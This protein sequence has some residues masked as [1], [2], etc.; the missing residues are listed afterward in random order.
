MA[1]SL[2]EHGYYHPTVYDLIF[3][4][5]LHPG[6]VAAVA[7]LGIG[8]G[9]QVLEVG[10]GTALTA[11]LYP[12]ACRVTAVDL[13]ASMLRRAKARVVRRGLTHVR[14]LASDATHLTFAD[15]SFDRVLAPYVISVVPDP[16]Q[17]LREMRRVCRPG[18]RIVILN[19]FRSAR[20]LM[21][22]V[23]RA[24][25]P[26]TRHIGFRADVD[27]PPLLEA[28]GLRTVRIQKVNWPPIWSAVTCARD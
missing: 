11:A 16:L 7:A 25:S 27:L 17:A 3:G 4:A 12:R 21:A 14:L 1:L 10:T 23:E 28:A 13:S 24:L 18:G 26:L 2:H 22:D 9:D 6:R 5:P 20:P 15:A 19:H 8:P